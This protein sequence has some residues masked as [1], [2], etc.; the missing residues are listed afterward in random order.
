MIEVAKPIGKKKR[1]D[2]K[3]L[4]ISVVFF[5]C[6]LIIAKVDLLATELF[7]AISL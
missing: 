1:F 5:R 7:S 6:V 4:H 3:K 2:L